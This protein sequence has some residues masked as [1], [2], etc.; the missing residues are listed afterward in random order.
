MT[1]TIPNT[2][3]GDTVATASDVNENF[4]Y[5][6]TAIGNIKLLTTINATSGTFTSSVTGANLVILAKT[7][8]IE[9]AGDSYADLILNLDG[10][11]LDTAS[12]KF[13][14]PSST[15]FKSTLPLEVLFTASIGVHTTSITTSNVG[16]A[17]SNTRIMIF[18]LNS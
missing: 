1:L 17:Q 10:S 2:F 9:T 16:C 15:E 18:Q 4:D 6:A 11:G 8:V 5:L 3:S 14:H 13:A 12:Y 7:I